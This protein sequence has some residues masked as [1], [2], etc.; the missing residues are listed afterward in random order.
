MLGINTRKV[1]DLLAALGGARPH[2]FP[3]PLP[4]DNLWLHPPSRYDRF[5]APQMTISRFV[6]LIYRM[7]AK[8]TAARVAV[9]RQLKKIGAVYLQQSVCIFPDTAATRRE[10]HPIMAKMEASS[11]SFH[12]LPLRSPSELERA[13]LISEFRGQSAKQYQEIIENCEINFQKE[14]EFETFRGNFT[15]EEAEEIRIEFDK[16]VGW[17]EAVT[18]R[19]WFG[20]SN[21]TEA[22]GWLT[23]CEKL[24]E[25][26]EA[27]VYEAQARAEEDW[28]GGRP[29][30]RRR[31]LRA[32]SGGGAS[33]S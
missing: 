8:P 3:T 20:A 25:R 11:G 16:I 1:N 18:R 19:D 28:D 14:I 24:L 6:V 31:R 29:P 32:L 21:R 17:F 23:R 26:F 13:K 7:P 27:Q 22:Q 15:Y 9:W 33:S 30:S 12:L 2:E 4:P 10:L 5:V